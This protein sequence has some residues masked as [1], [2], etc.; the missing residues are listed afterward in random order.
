MH[1]ARYLALSTLASVLL[2]SLVALGQT[3][4]PAGPT[5]AGPTPAEPAITEP[6]PATTAV[7]SAEQPTS[8]RLRQLEQRVQA[9]KEK[10]WRIKARVDLLKE[11]VLGGGIGARVALVHENQM[12]SAFRLVKLVYALDGVQIFARTD[13]TGKLNDMKK[14]DILSGPIEPGNHTV[15]LILVYHGQGYG[16]FSYMKGYKFTVKSSHTFTAS[17]GKLTEITGYGYEKGGPT[18]PMEK[19]PAVHF[20][21]NVVTGAPGKGK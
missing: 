13:E 1:P 9:L 16:V 19:K 3:P 21:V 6:A 10:S 18:T 5:P 20:K 14:V 15:S 17:E 4:P 12:G 8:I 2:L 7:A 11:A